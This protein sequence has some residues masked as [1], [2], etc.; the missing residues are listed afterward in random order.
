MKTILALTATCTVIGCGQIRGFQYASDGTLTAGEARQAA[1]VAQ[2]E[3]NALNDIADQH[4]QTTR[5]VIETTGTILE[6]VGAPEIISALVGAA[7]ALFVPPP[8]SRKKKNAELVK[9]EP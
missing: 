3:A 9:V 2:A 8:G 5:R 4:D 6:Q 1:S 7:A